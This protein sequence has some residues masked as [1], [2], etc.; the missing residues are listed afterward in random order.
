MQVCWNSHFCLFIYFDF[1]VYIAEGGRHFR[2]SQLPASRG[3]VQQCKT[4]LEW[5][6]SSEQEL[7]KC[8][9][10]DSLGGTLLCVSFYNGWERIFCKLC[11]IHEDFFPLM[12]G[13]HSA[14]VRWVMELFLKLSLTRLAFVK[15]PAGGMRVSLDREVTTATDIKKISFLPV[16]LNMWNIKLL[17]HMTMLQGC[18][19]RGEVHRQWARQ[20][21][22][23]SYRRAAEKGLWTAL[24]REKQHSL[25]RQQVPR[26][27]RRSRPRA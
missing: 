10:P 23:Q 19:A 25:W 14:F 11:I 1:D 21:A 5:S 7:W 15:R 17:F 18:A 2:T 24:S 6:L 20:G 16:P 26:C 13:C 4:H 9:G 22:A 8:W 3:F 27:W 12:I